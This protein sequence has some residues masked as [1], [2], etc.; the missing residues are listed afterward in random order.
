MKYLL[1]FVACFGV[2]CVYLVVVVVV[3]WKHGGGTIPMI[4]LFAALVGTW[5]AITNK[6]EGK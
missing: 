1:A 2:V 5:I 3:G 6:D 4:I